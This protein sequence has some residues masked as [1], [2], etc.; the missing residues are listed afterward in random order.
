MKQRAVQL[1]RDSEIDI[2][3]VILVDNDFYGTGISYVCKRVSII[4]IVTYELF[5][6]SVS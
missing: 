3:F 4:E 2:Q 6:Y 5:L 1:L